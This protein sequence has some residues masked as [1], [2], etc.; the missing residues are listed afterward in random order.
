MLRLKSGIHNPMKAGCLFR[1]AWS[2]IDST[3]LGKSLSSHYLLL[4][5]SALLFVL[6]AMP[7][8][9][10]SAATATLA[11]SPND[12][13][14]LEGYVVYRNRNTPGPPYRHSDVVPE[15]ELDDPLHPEV[16]LNGLQEG[17]EYYIALTA[18]NTEGIES[19][20]SEE[21]CATV[22]D[23][24]IELC[25]ESTSPPVT[26]SSSGGGGGGSSGFACFI[27]TASHRPS[28]KN[29]LLCILFSITA[30]GLGT[31]AYKK[32]LNSAIH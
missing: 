26:T 19:D 9:V 30:I 1:A 2:L 6:C 13:P 8:S 15:G 3:K 27:S 12:E 16:R 24:A 7:L 17:R 28:D 4:V 21:V 32:V 22:V 14:D 20:F 11:W 29:L 31:C 25:N 10:A 5:L 18:Y 23:N